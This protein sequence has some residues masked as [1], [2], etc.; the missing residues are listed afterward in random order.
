[1]SAM[2]IRKMVTGY[3]NQSTLWSIMAPKACF[4]IFGCFSSL[5]KGYSIVI[6]AIRTSANWCR[7]SSYLVVGFAVASTQRMQVAPRYI[8]KLSST[9]VN[10]PSYVL[11]GVEYFESCYRQLGAFHIVNICIFGTAAGLPLMA[12][13]FRG[14]HSSALFLTKINILIIYR[15]LKL[16]SLLKQVELAWNTMLPPIYYSTCYAVPGLILNFLL[17]GAAF[18]HGKLPLV[19]L[20]V[21][22]GL[23]AIVAGGSLICETK[24][25]TLLTDITLVTRTLIAN[26]F[27]SLLSIKK[28]MRYSLHVPVSLLLNEDS[29]P[30]VTPS[31]N[32]TL[33]YYLKTVKY[34]ASSVVGRPSLQNY[35]TINVFS[36]FKSDYHSYV[37]MVI[38][39]L[40]G[41]VLLASSMYVDIPLIKNSKRLSTPKGEEK[42]HFESDPD[43]LSGPNSKNSTHRRTHHQLKEQHTTPTKSMSFKIAE[44]TTPSPRKT[45]KSV[46]ADKYNPKEGCISSDNNLELGF[47]FA[48]TRTPS[49]SK[50][51]KNPMLALSERT[52]PV[53][54]ATIFASTTACSA[55]KRKS[56]TTLGLD[57]GWDHCIRKLDYGVQ[58][59]PVSPSKIPLPIR[60][61]SERKCRGI[62]RI[63]IPV[64]NRNSTSFGISSRTVRI[65]SGG[66]PSKI[67]MLKPKF[68]LE[69]ILR[70]V[71][72]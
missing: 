72:E 16:S 67:P 47:I 52:T 22:L 17:I 21:I 20:V 36:P 65:L 10:F 4:D 14:L 28:L 69:Q 44:N 3:I 46:K 61:I 42:Y 37:L 31:T 24:R 48:N 50:R 43:D 32:S 62:S 5:I 57:N 6:F 53:T 8:I 54:M 38:I 51:I 56:F 58:I 49:T 23:T 12:G 29:V 60:H 71:I 26:N 39:G 68:N 1:M 40:T 55:Q 45:T 59:K 15:L 34:L 11:E 63:P 2:I 7:V 9:I 13:N 27:V 64:R 30:S 35:L 70:V 41:A 19:T 18:R 33:N 25:M 66:S